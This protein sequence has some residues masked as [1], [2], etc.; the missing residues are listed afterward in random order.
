LEIRVLK[1]AHVRWKTV[2]KEE[3]L[4]MT[5]QNP[6]QALGSGLVQLEGIS[7]GTFSTKHSIKC[8]DFGSTLSA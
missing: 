3:R 2:L 6:K 4:Y 5:E 8:S 1:N 7:D